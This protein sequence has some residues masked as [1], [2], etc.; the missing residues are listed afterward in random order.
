M[1][2]LLV[3]VII[4]ICCTGT[5]HAFNLFDD[6]LANTTFPIGTQASAGTA[7]NLK[8]GNPATSL[9]A[10]VAEY[11]MF[12]LSYG[13]TKDTTSGAEFQDTLKVGFQLSWLFSKF[14]NPLPATASFLKNINIGP[15]YGFSVIAKPGQGYPFFDVN[16]TF[17][18]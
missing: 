11:R 1:K 3:S 10:P 16:Y 12:I 7:I 17:Q 13:A 9:L 5:V 18:G 4:S 8:N 14:T 6:V 15:S 2:K